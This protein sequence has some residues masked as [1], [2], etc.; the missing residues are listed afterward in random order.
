MS[1][2]ATIATLATP[3]LLLAIAPAI[4]SIFPRPGAWMLYLQRALSIPMF[5]TFAWLGWVLIHETTA[6]AAP[7][8]LP[9]AE[10]FSA[11]RLASYRAAGQPV[12]VDMT[13][14]WCVTCLVN[15]RSSLTV[16]KIQS[17]FTAA[18]V[19]VLVGDWTNRDPAITAYLQSNHRDGVP[20][21]VFY[22]A[23]GAAPKILPQ[24]LTPT[25]VTSFLTTD[26]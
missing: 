15:E 16:P 1:D 23:G 4:A 21:Y 24:I 22:P 18:H 3:V 19:H 25:L 14:A 20:L 6:S 5:A 2:L 8:T 26:D 10:P 11:A 12:F 17:A 9:G 7:L 13:A